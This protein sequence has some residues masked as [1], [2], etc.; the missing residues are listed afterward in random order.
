MKGER[1]ENLEQLEKTK[2]ECLEIKKYKEELKS[3]LYQTKKSMKTI[4][5]DLAQCKEKLFK[6]KQPKLVEDLI[7]TK[8][9][10]DVLHE[11][12][13]EFRSSS[14]TNSEQ[15]VKN[16]RKMLHVQNKAFLVSRD[17]YVKVVNEKQTLQNELRSLQG[18]ILLSNRR[19]S[20]FI[21][22]EG[23]DA[24]MVNGYGRNNI[25]YT[26]EEE[27]DEEDEG[28]GAGA[29][30]GKAHTRNLQVAKLLCVWRDSSRLRSI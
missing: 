20:K 16:L 8:G 17:D 1:R 30:R 19:P 26:D 10:L 18:Q 14:G 11:A 15:E 21:R 13:Q 24:Q 5:R 4:E 3:E 9:R 2:L 29:R 12:M 27:E 28:A 6:A 22:S 7:S 23:G 25:A